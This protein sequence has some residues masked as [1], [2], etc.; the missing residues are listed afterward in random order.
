MNEKTKNFREWVVL[1][2]VLFCVLD[3]A[4][5]QYG[6]ML[7]DTAGAH[8]NPVAGQIMEVIHG[9]RGA[10]L[11]AAGK[12]RDLVVFYGFLSGAAVALIAM[13]GVLVA[14]CI[15]RTRAIRARISARTQPEPSNWKRQDRP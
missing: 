7:T 3:V 1:L 13:L 10:L 2:F 4:A 9:T 15:G 8:R 5:L 14:H 12:G 11:N 6:M